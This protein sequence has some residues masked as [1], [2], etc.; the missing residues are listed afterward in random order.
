MT[1]E[2]RTLLKGSAAA[3]TATALGGPFAGFAASPAGARP[4]PRPRALV[5]IPDLRDGKVR[6]HI[7]R[8][9]Q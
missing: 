6:R 4:G 2:R 8:G 1:M 3:A 7:P 9:F 5:P